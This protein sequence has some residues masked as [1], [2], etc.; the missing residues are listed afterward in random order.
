MTHPSGREL[1]PGNRKQQA[2][3]RQRQQDD[4]KNNTGDSARDMSERL[5][6]NH[7][8]YRWCVCVCVRVTFIELGVLW[9]SR[10]SQ[11]IASLLSFNLCKAKNKGKRHVK[12]TR[13]QRQADH[14]NK[15]PLK[16]LCALRPV[17]SV[18]SFLWPT[19]TA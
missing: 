18:A 9:K 1:E 13:Q 11:P 15:T 17:A 4:G 10:C 3:K 5:C 7:W 8:P 2:R 19:V 14:K 16:P 6:V 12:C